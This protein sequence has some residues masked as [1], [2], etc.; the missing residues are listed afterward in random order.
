MLKFV[1][2]LFIVAILLP[3]SVYALNGIET[4]PASLEIIE[5]NSKTFEIIAT[6]ATG[7]GRIISSDPTVASVNKNAWESSISL[8]DSVNKQSVTVKGL[9]EG[10]ATIT[11]YID[12]GATTD[13]IDLT[14][15]TRTITVKVVAKPQTNTNNQTNTTVI[16]TQDEDITNIMTEDNTSETREIIFLENISKTEEKPSHNYKTILIIVG[17]VLIS[18]GFTLYI[19]KKK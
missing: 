5:G 6:E 19:I 15:Q 12:T 11:L 1:K 10:T 16:N 18:S 14:G 9:K 17:V 3:I 2:S 4:T 7:I 8:T 13:L